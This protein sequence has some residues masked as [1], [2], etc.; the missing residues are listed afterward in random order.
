MSFI[1]SSGEIFDYFLMNHLIIQQGYSNPAHVSR[2]GIANNMLYKGIS[3][4]EYLYDANQY[5]IKEKLNIHSG[6]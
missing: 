6:E 4:I 3:Y 5:A 1:S 2:N